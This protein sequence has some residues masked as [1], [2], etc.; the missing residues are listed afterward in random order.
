MYICAFICLSGVSIFWE[1]K[2]YTYICFLCRGPAACVKT[3]REYIFTTNQL[4]HILLWVRLCALASGE[5]PHRVAL[6]WYRLDGKNNKSQRVS[7]GQWWCSKIALRILSS[8]PFYVFLCS[9]PGVTT[10]VRGKLHSRGKYFISKLGNN[11]FK[12][13]SL[14][15]EHEMQRQCLMSEKLCKET[16]GLVHVSK[17]SYLQQRE[18]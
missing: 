13:I 18:S 3:A 1:I 11:L 5:P 9:Q 17:S 16:G 15:Y 7:V 6:C 8:S 14:R 2:K 10:G 12:F 4:D